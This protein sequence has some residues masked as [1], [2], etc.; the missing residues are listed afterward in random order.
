MTES[1]RLHNSAANKDILLKAGILEDLKRSWHFQRKAE[2]RWKQN[3]NG[4]GPLTLAGIVKAHA[5][6]C[7]QAVDLS[8]GREHY[9][10]HPL[11]SCIIVVCDRPDGRIEAQQD[12]Y[13]SLRD[14]AHKKTVLVV[15]TGSNTA[16]GASPLSLASFAPFALPLERAD[17][18]GLDVVRVSLS[19]AVK[20]ITDLEAQVHD[21]EVTDGQAMDR[22]LCCQDWLEGHPN[23][24]FDPELWAHAM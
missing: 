10:V 12:G 15:F 14:V 24:R 2:S 11:Y 18:I 4:D 22:S 9:S 1:E 13:V 5:S 20:F 16:N 21:R 8:L 7:A 19:T 23:V 3:G 6:L 17:V